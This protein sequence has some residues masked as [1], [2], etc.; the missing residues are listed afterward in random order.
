MNKYLL[1]ISVLSF[2][3]CVNSCKVKEAAGAYRPAENAQT[4]QAKPQSAP[5]PTTEVKPETTPAR[6]NP[7]VVQEEE[8]VRVEAFKVVEGEDVA[9]LKHYHVVVG[10]FQNRINA[11]NLQSSL[12][13]DYAPVIVVN[14]QGMFR[15]LLISFDDYVSA[16]QK[17]AE[18]KSQFGDAWVLVQK[19]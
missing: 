9:A 19:Q 7:V 13:D 18:I 3:L 15:V 8:K 5:A 1:I 11:Q 4:P 2:A 6:S 14:E 10:S 16:K 12:Q 17:I